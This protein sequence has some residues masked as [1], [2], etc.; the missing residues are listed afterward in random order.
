MEKERWPKAIFYDSKS[1]LWDWGLHI[2]ADV[3]AEIIKKYGITNVDPKEFA[4]KW[5]S[6]HL[7]YQHRNAF[8]D[9]REFKGCHQDALMDVCKI[10]GVPG[11]PED[12]EFMD[13]Q[14]GNIKPYPDT[15]A[16]LKEQQKLTKVFIFS[17]VEQAHLEAMVDRLEG[18]KPDFVGTMQLARMA[19]P[20]P[21][22]YLWV[23]KKVNL[24][25]KDVIYCAGP[26][27][28]V[29]GAMATGMKAAHIDRPGEEIIAG[30][31][32]GGVKPDWEIKNLHELTKIVESSIPGR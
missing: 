22:A 26:M 30:N 21:Q 25:V 5:H 10:F 12:V 11:K 1:T 7:G 31:D 19:K 28:D 6:I 14:L 29:Q 17:N 13:A 18:F 16:A 20:N 8:A 15:I 27:W 4:N 3:A 23:L 9:Y 24:D 32:D 2:W